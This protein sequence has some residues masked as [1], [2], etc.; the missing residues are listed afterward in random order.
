MSDSCLRRLAWIAASLL[1]AGCCRRSHHH[2]GGS[3]SPVVGTSDPPEVTV[4]ERLFLETRFAQFFATHLVGNDVNAPLAA[5]DPTMETIVKADGTT[6]PGPFAGQ[7]VNCRHCH[8]VDELDMV[9][10]GGIRTYG[11]FGR[12]APIPDRYDGRSTTPRNTPPLVNA[13]LARSTDFFLHYDGEFVTTEE[14]VRASLT[15]RNLG[16]RADEAAAA[17]A[18]IARVIRDDNGKGTLAADFGGLSYRDTFGAAASVP[19]KFKLPAGFQLNVAT[20]TDQEILDAIARLIKAYLDSLEFARDANGE[21]N[22]SPFDLFLKKNGLP[23]KPDPG[24]HPLAYSRRLRGLVDA[25]ATPKFVTPADGSFVHHA[26]SFAFGAEELA[27]L[28]IFLQE[29]SALPPTAYELAVGGI[30][31]C[32]VCH[33]G[34]ELTDFEFHNVGTA[35]AEYEEIHGGGSFACIDVPSLSKRN[36]K[37]KKYLPPSAAEPDAESIFLR[38]PVKHDDRYTDLGLWN[39]FA[40]PNVPAPQDALREL[41]GRLNGLDPDDCDDDDDDEDLLPLTIGLFKTPGLR[42]LADGAP[43][44][45]TGQFDQIEDVISHY[46]FEADQARDDRV[47]NGDPQLAGIALH[48]ADVAALAA[49]LR[50]LNEDYD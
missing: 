31:N 24:E 5:G 32:V 37:P 34:P 45:H 41:I 13:S 19:A 9:S 47:V 44:M 27:G 21:F 18:H 15:G 42:D 33:Y 48:S 4:G 17:S 7:S 50:S 35:Q 20:A 11:D 40:N 14:L 39:V 6:L 8:L 30:G 3:N 49:F 16:W 43:Y 28:K 22:G 23:R 29:P 36:R 26:Q 2:H 38:V 1:V 10:G 25:I 46:V 12:R